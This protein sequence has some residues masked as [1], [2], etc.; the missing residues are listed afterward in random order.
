MKKAVLIVDDEAIIVLSL[1]RELRKALGP[2][3]RIETALSGEDAFLVMRELSEEGCPPSVV[4]SDWYMPGLNGDEFLVRTRSL[5]PDASLIMI[6]G[7]SDDAAIERAVRAA[8]VMACVR[9]PWRKSELIGL[10]RR[11]VNGTCAVNGAEAVNGTCAGRIE[12]A[13]SSR[14]ERFRTDRD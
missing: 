14:D 8:D 7:Q 1:M 9:K 12:A 13:G 2:D 5:Y 6:T 3:V 4:I 10:I 11:A